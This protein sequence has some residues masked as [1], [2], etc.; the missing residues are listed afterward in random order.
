MF[1]SLNEQGEVI[2]S[3]GESKKNSWNV[4]ECCKPPIVRTIC[5]TK[6]PKKKYLIEV[7]YGHHFSAFS[8]MLVIVYGCCSNNGSNFDVL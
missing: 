1:T 3:S 2:Q 8:S 7:T 6:C 5:F 4:W